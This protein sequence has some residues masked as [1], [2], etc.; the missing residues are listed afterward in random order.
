[1]AQAVKPGVRVTLSMGA[2]P[3]T[4]VVGGQQVLEGRLALPSGA[5]GNSWWCSGRG[6]IRWLRQLLQHAVVAAHQPACQHL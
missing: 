3:T 5:M 4:R 6:S 1:M 2:Q